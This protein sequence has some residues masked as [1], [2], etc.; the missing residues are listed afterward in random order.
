MSALTSFAWTALTN[1]LTPQDFAQL[2]RRLLPSRMMSWYYVMLYAQETVLLIM[3]FPGI[4]TPSYERLQDGKYL[5]GFV[6]Q[7]FH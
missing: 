6:L 2:A 1:Y 4:V 5:P 3:K 7:M